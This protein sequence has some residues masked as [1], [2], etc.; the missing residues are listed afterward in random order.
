M[1]SNFDKYVMGQ[2]MGKFHVTSVHLW[3]EHLLALSL[4]VVIPNPEPFW[5]WRE[6][7]F[8]DSAL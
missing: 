8:A 1:E 3:L 7:P 6:L 4:R 2:T 5:P